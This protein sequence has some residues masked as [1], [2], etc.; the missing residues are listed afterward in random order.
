MDEV[1][2]ADREEE[3]ASLRVRRCTYV[4]KTGLR[5]AQARQHPFHVSILLSSVHLY[6]KEVLQDEIWELEA[7]NKVERKGCAPTDLDRKR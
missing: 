5:N 4:N 7:K 2:K 1:Q 3:G 6:Y